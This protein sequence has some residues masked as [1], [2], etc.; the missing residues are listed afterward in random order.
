MLTHAMLLAGADPGAGQKPE[1]GYTTGA[2]DAC[3]TK[4]KVP[5]KKSLR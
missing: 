5:E 1:T 2:R 3:K 4:K